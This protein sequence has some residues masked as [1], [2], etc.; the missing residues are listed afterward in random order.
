MRPDFQMKD[1]NKNIVYDS[2]DYVYRSE[3]KEPDKLTTDE[4]AFEI[5]TRKFKEMGFEGI[6]NW[7]QNIAKEEQVFDQMITAL[8]KEKKN[9][10][11]DIQ[12][13]DNDTIFDRVK[14]IIE[15]DIWAEAIMVALRSA[16]RDRLGDWWMFNNMDFYYQSKED[17]FSSHG[18]DEMYIISQVQSWKEKA[19]DHANAVR[20][21][22]NSVMDRNLLVRYLEDP[23]YD[24]SVDE[25]L[26]M[27]TASF[28]NS[29]NEWLTVA[30]EK[31]NFFN[32]IKYYVV[33]SVLT[34]KLFSEEIFLFYG[35]KIHPTLQVF[36]W[37]ALEGE[38]DRESG[39]FYDIDALSRGK[40]ILDKDE[41]TG[42][43][44]MTIDYS[45]EF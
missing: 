25:K 31:K 12:N 39:M 22:W 2:K 6:I 14:R 7:V 1:K 42:D 19:K 28:A 10:Y 5:T 29:L 9:A 11:E 18:L 15:L 37:T 41:E 45:R 16:E 30:L 33:K 34:E 21:N 44:T 20:K 24:P 13:S 4:I 27:Q 43:L 40:F 8:K 3:E 17:Y 23:E 35:K 26:R 32:S 36:L 38:F